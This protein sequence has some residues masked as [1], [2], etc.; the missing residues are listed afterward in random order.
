MN[1]ELSQQAI[2][3]VAVNF[4]KDIVTPSCMPHLNFI[5]LKAQINISFSLWHEKDYTE[6]TKV[7]A[8]MQLA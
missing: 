2:V 5:T 6:H 7:H 1:T 4:L 8:A 3:G